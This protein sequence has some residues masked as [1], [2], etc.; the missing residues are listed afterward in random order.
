MIL[1]KGSGTTV[2]SIREFNTYL[3]QRYFNPQNNT[4]E[5]K[6]LTFMTSTGGI[7]LKIMMQNYST[8]NPNFTATQRTYYNYNISGYALVK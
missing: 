1:H 3:Q 4:L 7:I 8:K 5:Q 2:F 6:D